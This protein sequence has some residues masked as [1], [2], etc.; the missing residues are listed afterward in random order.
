MMYCLVSR[1]TGRQSF[2]ASKRE[3][4]DWIEVHFCMTSR[5]SLCFIDL[6]HVRVIRKGRGSNYSVIWECAERI[7]SLH[8]YVVKH[9]IL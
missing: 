7:C 6:H 4:L 2:V 9:K 5:S 3:L 1:R 8:E